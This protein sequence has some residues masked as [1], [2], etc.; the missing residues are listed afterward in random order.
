MKHNTPPLLQAS[1]DLEK[2]VKKAGQKKPDTLPD[3]IYLSEFRLSAGVFQ[4]RHRMDD[5][6]TKDLVK[7]LRREG[8]LDPILV[9]QLGKHP[10]VV[11][12]HHR[13]EAYRKVKFDGLI[14]V[15]YF[16][17]SVQAAI[18]AAGQ[19]NTRAKLQMSNWERQDFAWRLVVMGN[20]SKSEIVKAAGV[21]DGQ[22]G[23]MRRV[24][25][26]LGDDAANHEHWLYAVQAARDKLQPDF[27][28][29]GIEAWIDKRSSELADKLRKVWGPPRHKHTSVYAAAL[30]K[31][32]G[33]ALKDLMARL[34]EEFGCEDE[35][36]LDLI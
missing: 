31:Y 24:K 8:Q 17:G 27:N 29:V 9:I 26:I 35:E 7:A 15:T 23:T 28:D 33:G 34:A 14:P 12:G 16:E 5:F 11:D 4:P 19:F 18:L 32:F 22:V 6:H 2:L 25:K 30:S 21:S 1:W 10:Y 36:E 20:A 3:K 13:L